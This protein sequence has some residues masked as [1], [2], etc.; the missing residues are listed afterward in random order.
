MS[1][2]KKK[3]LA[4][5]CP[6]LPPQVFEASM[7]KLNIQIQRNEQHTASTTYCTKEAMEFLRQCHSQFVAL[8]SSELA[9]GQD[10]K[11]K[12]KRKGSEQQNNEQDT[13]R[14][15]MPNHIKPA[16]EQ[17]E[18]HDIDIDRLAEPNNPIANGTAGGQQTSSKSLNN[19]KRRKAASV[20]K[21]LNNSAMTEDLLKEQEKLFAM[22]VAKARKSEKGP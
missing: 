10:S 2:E 20:K 11:P 19:G 9:S 7:G 15:I 1:S 17:L 3:D 16:L 4:S 6:V 14:T 8:L 21:S 18:F 5:T 22:S 12:S 13:I